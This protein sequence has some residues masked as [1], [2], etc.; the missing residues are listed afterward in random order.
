M[1]EEQVSY[2][3]FRTN[4]LKYLQETQQGK[5]IVI[6]RGKDKAVEGVLISPQDYE[7]LK[8]K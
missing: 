2:T 4:L 3:N 8:G 5:A 6:V 7:K 1:E